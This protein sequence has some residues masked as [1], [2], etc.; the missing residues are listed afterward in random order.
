VPR[1]R[2]RIVRG[3]LRSSARNPG[4]ARAKSGNEIAREEMRGAVVDDD[5]VVERL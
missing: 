1:L 3:K 2:F 5:F 4:R